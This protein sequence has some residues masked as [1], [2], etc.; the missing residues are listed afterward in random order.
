M[1]AWV[2]AGSGR[3]PKCPSPYH[4]QQLSVPV[5]QRAIPLSNETL[6]R[7]DLAPPEPGD[8]AVR[9]L[10]VKQHGNHIQYPA[11]APLVC[12]SGIPQGSR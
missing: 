1:A 7:N 9:G 3:L 2:I 11:A 5:T 6:E 4:G 12:R 8:S 10:S